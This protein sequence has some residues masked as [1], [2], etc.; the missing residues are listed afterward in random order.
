MASFFIER[1][2]ESSSGCSLFYMTVDILLVG[3]GGTGGCLFARMMR[4]L[5]DYAETDMEITFRIMDG[6]HVELKN[7]ARQPFSEEDLGKNKAVALAAS[8]QE[9]FGIDVKAYP[10]YL[11]PDNMLRYL[12]P[13]S[14]SSSSNIRIII[15]AVDNHACRKLLHEY[16]QHPQYLSENVL[17]Y[18]DSANE[19]SCG[20][21]VIG[22]RTYRDI[23]APDRVHYYPDIMQDNGKAAYEMSCEELNSSAPQHLAT[24]GLAADLIF[25]YLAQLLMAGEQAPLAPGGIIYFDAL[26]LF[27]RF[28]MRDEQN[29]LI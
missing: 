29:E 25:S 24:N 11:T 6:D 28:D 8:A 3:C 2:Q 5:Y 26:K 13:D 14:Y 23:A 7:L 9:V 10:E 21:I 17:Y 1:R 15:G 22:K 19:F 18:I 12:S 16:F 27:S 4:F 20:E